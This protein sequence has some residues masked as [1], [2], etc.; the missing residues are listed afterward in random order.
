ME[1]NESVKKLIEYH[2][3]AEPSLIEIYLFPSKEE[4][5]LVE[6]DENT[7]CTEGEQMEAWYLDAYP[8]GGIVLPSGLALIHPRE[9]GK[10]IP[11]D[12]WGTW[13][14]AELVWSRAWAN[15]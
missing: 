14:E 6:V 11:P 2:T 9:V 4:I 5:H 15:A 3:E 12:G 7:T 13:G 1:M 8:E 10:L